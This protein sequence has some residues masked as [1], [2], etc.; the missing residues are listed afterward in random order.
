M[1]LSAQRL[2][3]RGVDHGNAGR[4]A[5]AQ[6]ALSTAMSRTED[7]DLRARIT[8][9]LAYIASRR[10]DPATAE[11]LCRE[12]LADPRL[13][14]TTRA[15]LSGQLGVL[16]LMRGDAIAARELLTRGIGGL[17]DD[18]ARSGR[19]RINRSVAAMQ[20]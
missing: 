11:R 17:E 2:Y 13:G 1:V 19:M 8:G 4:H 7:V 5:A 6:R 3:E 10:G 14:A 9:T 16:A 18:P 12:G 15:I 20:L